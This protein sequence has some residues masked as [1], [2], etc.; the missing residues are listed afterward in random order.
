MTTAVLCMVQ[1]EYA[2]VKDAQKQKCLSGTTPLNSWPTVKGAHWSKCAP[3]ECNNIGVACAALTVTHE[4]YW[5]ANSEL[6]TSMA[7]L[8]E[9]LG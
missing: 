7:T 1:L 4:P 8:G 9:S 5:G 6:L 2:G 3:R